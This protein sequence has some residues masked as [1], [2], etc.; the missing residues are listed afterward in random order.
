MVVHK[1]WL[2]CLLVALLAGCAG[3]G[4]DSPSVDATAMPGSDQALDLSNVSAAQPG[5]ALAKSPVCS[6][7]AAA[8]HHAPLLPIFQVDDRVLVEAVIAVFGDEVVA[9]QE[10]RYNGDSWWTNVTTRDGSVVISRSAER[11]FQWAR[12]DRRGPAM[13]FNASIAATRSRQ[14][15]EAVGAQREPFKQIAMDSNVQETQAVGQYTLAWTNL[16]WGTA[17]DGRLSMSYWLE[18][19][20]DTSA[21]LLGIAAKAAYEEAMRAADCR[22]RSD[23]LEDL[24]PA[25]GWGMEGAGSG[26]P[27]YERARLETV[28]DTLTYDFDLQS[29]FVKCRGGMDATA[30]HVNVDTESGEAVAIQYRHPCPR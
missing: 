13:D 29:G 3:P 7:P 20:H 1:A 10:G 9:V 11:E 24:I 4:V 5:V 12:Y 30:I 16:F 8:S 26:R 19:I 21:A 6:R 18:G 23:G 22:L 27:G 14:V 2:A 17:P 28:R 25:A 15:L